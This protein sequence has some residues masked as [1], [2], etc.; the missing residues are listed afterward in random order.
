[1]QKSDIIQQDIL[2]QLDLVARRFDQAASTYDQAAILQQRTADQLIERCAFLNLDVQRILDVGTGTGYALPKLAALFPEAELH[3]VDAAPSMLAAAQERCQEAGLKLNTYCSDAHHLP[4]EPSSIDLVFCNLMA[5]W[6]PNPPQLW[7]QLLKALKPGGC[8]M[9]ATYGPDTLKELKA[10]W[11]QVDTAQHVNH[12]LDMHDIGDQLRAAGFIDPVM[13]RSES[14]LTYGRVMDLCRD[15]KAVGANSI[16]NPAQHAPR[17]LMGQGKFAQ[18]CHAYQAYRTDAD[19][20]P[21]SY[22]VI[23]A[24]AWAGEPRSMTRDGVIEIPIESI[25]RST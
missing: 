23:F 17:G 1:M 12:F 15:L 14:I 8:L 18:L 2:N 13:D 20:Y 10:S 22:E 19:K 21:A 5:Q 24:H 7:T 11:A 25:K 16:L 6:S 3:A 4:I 9:L